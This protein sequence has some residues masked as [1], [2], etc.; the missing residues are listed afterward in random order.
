MAK[1]EGNRISKKESCNILE[2]AAKSLYYVVE[3]RPRTLNYQAYE[4][5]YLKVESLIK[6]MK[7]RTR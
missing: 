5:T 6:D 3:V 7:C 1:R 2:E 4:E